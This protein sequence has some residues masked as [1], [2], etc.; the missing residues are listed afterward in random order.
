M[1]KQKAVQLS[2]RPLFVCCGEKGEGGKVGGGASF[3]E[4]I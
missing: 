1:R 2:I 4:V 3:G